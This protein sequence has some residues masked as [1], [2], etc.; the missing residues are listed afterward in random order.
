MGEEMAVVGSSSLSQETGHHFLSSPLLLPPPLPPTP[1]LP[2]SPLQDLLDYSFPGF[3]ACPPVLC[4][5]P[6]RGS[7]TTELMISPSTVS[8]IAVIIGLDPGVFQEYKQALPP[9]L[10]TAAPSLPWIGEKLG[11]EGGW[12]DLRNFLQL[13]WTGP[14]PPR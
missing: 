11:R 7:L 12:E 2:P 6:G 10:V 14:C 8:N 4:W 9:P 5:C 3:S 13:H 1:H